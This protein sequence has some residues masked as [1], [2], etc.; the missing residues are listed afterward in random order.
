MRYPPGSFTKN[1]AWHGQGMEK[2]HSAIRAGFDNALTPISREEWRRKSGIN[3]ADLELLPIN[4]FLHNNEGKLSVDE[5]VFQAI[6]YNHSIKFDQLSLFCFHLNQVGT[7]P[8]GISRPALWANEFVRETLWNNSVWSTA[9]L[10]KDTLDSVINSKVDADIGVKIKCRTN[11]RHL[12]E[13]CGYLPSRLDTINSMSDNWLASAFF[14]AWDRYILEHGETT[15]ESLLQYIDDNE[16]YKL[17]GISK[18]QSSL[19]AQR[20][21]DFYITAGNIQR[22]QPISSDKRNG[23]AEKAITTPEMLDQY[24]S[25]DSVERRTMEVQAQIRDRNISVKLKKSYKNVCMICGK[26]LMISE[27]DSYSEAAHIKPIGYPHNGPDKTSNILILC[28]NHHIQFD[29]GVLWLKEM[30]GKYYIKSL[31]ENDPL[32]GKELLIEH[33]LDTSC[34]SWHAAWFN[35]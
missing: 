1:F 32:D 19:Q 22:F 2:L 11:Y 21:V 29:R 34:V 33:E 17:C 18:E 35:R 5:L 23:I 31:I 3:D 24:G 10:E 13:L 4:F 6:Q 27:A 16:V 30:D 26:S 25:D 15:R 28:P 7:P 9:S 20:L 12:F 14:L 8:N